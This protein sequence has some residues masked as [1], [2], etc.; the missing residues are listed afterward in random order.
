MADRSRWIG[1]PAR[2]IMSKA[3]IG[4]ILKNDL[5]AQCVR[6]ALGVVLRYS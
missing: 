3:V 5:V 6:L 2:V 4:E 1:D